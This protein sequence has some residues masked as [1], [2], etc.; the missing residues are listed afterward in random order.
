L[1]CDCKYRP[2]R[3]VLDDLGHILKFNKD[4]E[5]LQSI[6]YD[7]IVKALYTVTQEAK[8]SSYSSVLTP[9]LMMR[10]I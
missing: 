1:K 7:F 9:I 10:Q 6:K 2:V 8:Y 3:K 5:G 4:T